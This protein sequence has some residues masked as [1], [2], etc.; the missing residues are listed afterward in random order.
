MYKRQGEG[1][2][3]R[4][5]VGDVGHLRDREGADDLALEHL[6][7]GDIGAELAQPREDRAGGD[8]VLAVGQGFERGGVDAD[9]SSLAEVADEDRVDLDVGAEVEGEVAVV[10]GLGDGGGGGCLLY[11]SRCV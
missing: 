6:E 9:A 8:A 10:A 1:V 2:P 11:T 5:E 7:A 3:G 4:A